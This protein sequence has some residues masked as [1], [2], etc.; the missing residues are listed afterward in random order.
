M[1]DGDLL[2][3]EQQAAGVSARALEWRAPARCSALCSSSSTSNAAS[4]RAGC[5]DEGGREHRVP[6]TARAVEILK[7][8]AAVRVSDFVF[9]VSKR[10]APLSNMALAMT[11]RRIGSDVTVHGFRSTFRDWASERT[12]FP[13]DVAEMALARRGDLFEK[14]LALME[15]WAG[16]LQARNTGSKVVALSTR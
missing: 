1:L 5:A 4:D 10:V 8:M 7:G 13:S 12:S 3:W 16:F 2:P 15:A 14:R 6:L 9:P 11:L